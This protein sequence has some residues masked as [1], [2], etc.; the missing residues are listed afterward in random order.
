MKEQ[1]SLSSPRLTG[2]PMNRARLT[3]VLV[4]LLSFSWLAPRTTLAFRVSGGS[5]TSPTKSWVLQR[6][7]V[8][9]PVETTTVSTGQKHD[10]QQMGPLSRRRQ[11]QQQHDLVEPRTK[12]PSWFS[13]ALRSS[14]QQ[15][16]PPPQEPLHPLVL[17]LLQVAALPQSR[18]NRQ[19]VQECLTALLDATWSPQEG[20]RG[21]KKKKKWLESSSSFRR[22]L[23]PGSSSRLVW[24][25]VTAHSWWGALAQQPPSMVLGG[26][27]W[28]VLNEDG[29]RVE[30]VVYWKALGNLRMVGQAR[31]SPTSSSSSSFSTMDPNPSSYTVEICGLEFRW[32]GGRTCPEQVPPRMQSSSS[33]LSSS[34]SQR[35]S[36]LDLSSSDSTL[37][38]NAVGELQVLYHDGLVRITRDVR[39]KNTYIHIQEPVPPALQKALFSPSSSSNSLESMN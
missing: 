30:N 36:V 3:L 25:T 39:L 17:P 18:H 4:S 23:R 38:P 7:I 5:S 1:R 24:S 8:S 9:A 11:Q 34:P 37:G 26:P 31:L 14:V 19:R 22:P 20:D 16:A 33:S 12:I 2:Q 28:Q 6:P 10:R 29:T 27:S 32:G 21:H 15:Q 35:W 13:T